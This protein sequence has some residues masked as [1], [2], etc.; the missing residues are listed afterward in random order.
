LKPAFRLLQA[1]DGLDPGLTPEQR[2][3]KVSQIL[4]PHIFRTTK[5]KRRQTGRDGQGDID[6]GTPTA[7]PPGNPRLDR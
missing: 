6:V 7:N 2:I 3:D 5:E 4:A 1:F